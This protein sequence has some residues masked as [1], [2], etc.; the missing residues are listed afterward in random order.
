VR[1]GKGPGCGKDRTDHRQ[2][3]G[4][5]GPK[6]ARVFCQGG[7]SKSQ[8]KVHLHGRHGLYS[9]RACGRRGQVLRIRLPGV[10]DLHAR[11]PF[12]AI[13]MSEDSLPIISKE[14]CTACGK[15]VAACP[16]QVIELGSC[17]RR[18]SSAAIA[19][20]RASMSRRECQ[21]GCIAC[22]ICVRTCPGRRHQDRQQ[23]GPHRSQQMHHLW[24]LREEVPHERDP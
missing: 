12:D 7:R 1:A 18:S 24:S 2:S 19:G 13:R 10:C 3:S 20:T 16:K 22:G 8:R 4:K 21:V 17:R 9:G 14:K 6:I 15:C 11:L 5:G 23:P